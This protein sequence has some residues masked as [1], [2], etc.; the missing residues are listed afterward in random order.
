MSRADVAALS[1][2]VA[3]GLS[4]APARAAEEAYAPTPA[5]TYVARVVTTTTAHA[6]PDAG[7]P[8]RMRLGTQTPWVRGPLRLLVLEARRD[9]DGLLWVR[10][11]LPKRPNTAD[12][13]VTEN[14]VR[15][16]TNPY[17]VEVRTATR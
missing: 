8:V 4:A 5:R 2:A 17:R 12:G 1:A 3:L 14:H 11:R 15:L 6:A 16:S 9:E 10:V 13:W 7:S